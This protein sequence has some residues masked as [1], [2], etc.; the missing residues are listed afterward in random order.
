MLPEGGGQLPAGVDFAVGQEGDKI[1]GRAAA[2]AGA[3]PEEGDPLS[4][5]EDIDQ[6]VLDPHDRVAFPP[7]RR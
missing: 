7:P 1:E 6:V 4:M 5:M 2:E 3:A